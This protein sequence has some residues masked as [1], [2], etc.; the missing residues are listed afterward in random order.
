MN[1]WK[2][3]LPPLIISFFIS[4]SENESRSS[5]QRRIYVEYKTTM[6]VTAINADEDAMCEARPSTRVVGFS[7]SQSTHLEFPGKTFTRRKSS[8]F[9]TVWIGFLYMSIPLPQHPPTSKCT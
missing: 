8:M 6:S 5:D 3:S 1:V 9:M 7:T 4:F 2:L